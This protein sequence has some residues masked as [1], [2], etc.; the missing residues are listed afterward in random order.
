M[1]FFAILYFCATGKSSQLPKM[2]EN[3]NTKSDFEQAL[4]NLK[5]SVTA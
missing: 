4:S 2:Q 3:K 1:I 5:P